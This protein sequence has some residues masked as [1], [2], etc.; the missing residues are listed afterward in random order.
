MKQLLILS[1][2]AI[3]L[4]GCGTEETS[5][6]PSNGI[7]ETEKLR[8]YLD[9]TF[10]A[11]VS[12]DPQWESRL[13]IRDHYDQWS[14]QSDEHELEE[15]DIRARE[16][17][18]MEKRI[19]FD[20]LDAQGKISYRLIET[21][22]NRD[23]AKRPYIY[24]SYPV[25]Q[26]HGI[27]SEIPSF[28]INVHRIDSVPD[29]EAYI[30]RMERM[31]GLMRQVI[32]KL[33]KRAEMNII[34][35]KFVFPLV[36]GDCENIISGAP[37]KWGADTSP[38]WEDYQS[39]IE[40]ADFEAS[41]KERLLE[42]GRQAI[43]DSVEAAYS[44]LIAKLKELEAKAGTDDGVWRFDKGAEFYDY[45]LQRTTTTNMTADEIHELGLQEVA[46]IHG[47]MEEIMKN[48]IKLRH[49][50]AY[51]STD[52]GFRFRVEIFELALRYQLSDYETFEYRHN[53]FL[54]DYEELLASPEFEKDLALIQLIARM[55]EVPQ[56]KKDT[57]LMA[58]IRQFL[59]TYEP[60]DTEIFK[61]A[62][63][64]EANA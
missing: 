32:Q 29:A 30:G 27:H 64:L 41:E 16:F 20:A 51:Q 36:I 60:D 15:M 37:F 23:A 2:L 58:D 28:L 56:V 17:A 59:D 54:Q 18:E 46:R 49:L 38:L 62:D 43:L 26:M 34:P 53:Q 5:K 6:D 12:R 55:N 40:K 3:V 44:D 24:Y 52:P 63:F 11:A 21:K 25:E 9:S 42:E 35:P 4:A 8:V 48:L 47:E 13:G 57:E 22:V 19:N 10:D 45:A 61:Y 1:L 14:N 33:D 39:K 31:P 7:S 50:D